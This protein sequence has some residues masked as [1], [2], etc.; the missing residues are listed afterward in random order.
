MFK[1]GYKE[2]GMIYNAE[3][4]IS[5]E[6][7][8][9]QEMVVENIRN[10][11]IRNSFF[12][13]FILCGQYGSGKTTMARIISM[14]ANCEKKDERGNPCG[15]CDS[16]QA[17]LN[18]SSEGIIEVDGASNNGIE[19]IRKLLEQAS[20][21]GLYNKKVIVIDEAHKLSNAAFNA[22]LITLENPPSHCIFILCTTEK[23]AL[24]DTIVSRAPVYNFSKIQDDLIKKHVLE[25]ALKN[26]IAISEDAAG[27]LAR[28]SNGAMRNALQLLEHLSIQKLSEEVIEEKD[29]VKTLGLS[30]MEQRA[31]FLE[32][33][34][35]ADI[36]E[37]V[38][39]LRECEQSG[40]SLR[41]F[42]Q[43]VLEM[44]TDLLLCRAGSDVVGTKFYKMKLKELCAYS[45]MT[46]V[47]AN[48]M[49]STIAATPA[50][51]LSTER[52]V[53]DIV[54]VM[55]ETPCVIEETRKE[56]AN[57]SI[58][59]KEVH[60]PTIAVSEGNEN[61]KEEAVKEKDD[62]VNADDDSV[63]GH[64]K[65][66]FCDVTDETEI[67]FK[68]IEAEEGDDKT[69]ADNNTT[70]S[71]DSFSF[72]GGGF[73]DSGFGMQ[74][75]K[76]KEKQESSV[77]LLYSAAVVSATISTS[78][79][80]KEE[81][82]SLDG[83]NLETTDEVVVVSKDEQVQSF[84]DSYP[85]NMEGR[86]R[87]DEAAKLGLVLEKE[88]I[89]LPRPE[90][91]E[92]LD[93]MY[94]AMEASYEESTEEETEDYA[95]RMDLEEARA[96]LSRLLKNPGFKIL[97]NKAKVVEEKNQIHLYFDNQSLSVAIKIFLKG[98]ENIFVH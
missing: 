50:N 65:D 26:K 94:E 51:L 58:T 18:H 39:I 63:N 34:L 27:I 71:F 97:Y 95:S 82:T 30:S 2:E 49:L 60:N 73:F 31:A 48:R 10:Q 7:M 12:P 38:K 28:Y 32:S 88:K 93:A 90:T 42:I 69:E 1:D 6:Q 80:E 91:S 89:T 62:K 33:I 75:Q 53:A 36:Q 5:F 87:W 14:A 83:E 70:V 76:T 84:K 44:N 37:S 79:S 54:S 35:G 66:G 20:V 19:S 16:C 40:R 4:P 24:P 57:Q 3:R 67:P 23:D 8:I 47:R 72:F 56:S 96:E 21:M 17:V 29:V 98:A 15:V 77:N 9:G 68:V 85:P 41:T 43:D 11:S 61:L 55:Y 86:M 78:E 25:V 74:P 64:T 81:D 22:L 59:L 13:V 92:Q 52:I 46:I 45:N